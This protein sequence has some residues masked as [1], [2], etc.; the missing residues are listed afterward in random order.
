VR[1]PGLEQQTLRQ[2]TPL[3]GPIV[4]LIQKQIIQ[5]FGV[6]VSQTMLGTPVTKIVCHLNQMDSGMMCPVRPPDN[7][8]VRNQTRLGQL[9]LQILP[10]LVHQ[11][12]LAS[13]TQES[14]TRSTPH[15]W[16]LLNF[17]R[18]LVRQ[19][20]LILHLLDQQ[21]SRCLSGLSWELLHPTDGL[22]EKTKLLMVLLSGLM[23]QASPIPIGQLS[24]LSPSQEE[25]KSRTACR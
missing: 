21:R 12:G 11:T 5:H 23:G 10:V 1:T 2:K 6:V 13:S 20:A 22:E 15:S 24:T 17:P 18:Q 16:I 19:T 8:F 9:W 7:I 14:V 25:Q 4:L 3:S